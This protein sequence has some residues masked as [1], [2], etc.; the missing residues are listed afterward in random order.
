MSPQFENYERSELETY[1]DETITS[2]YLDVA[3]ARQM[4]LN[5]VEAR[6]NVLYRGMGFTSLEEV[7]AKA[8][9]QGTK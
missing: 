9:A 2:Y 6:Y 5:L 3:T 7:E 4:G 1:S 8:A